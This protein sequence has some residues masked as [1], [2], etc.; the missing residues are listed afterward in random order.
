MS[1]HATRDAALERKALLSQTLT[2]AALAALAAEVAILVYVLDK[3]QPGLWFVL[4][5][6][7]ATVAEVFSILFG[8]WGMG[9]I[10]DAQN[11][12]FNLQAIAGVLGAAL[13][14]GS[15]FAQGKPKQDEMFAEL[16]KVRDS[17]RALSQN[18]H[19]LELRVD[20]LAR[21]PAFPSGPSSSL[22]GSKEPPRKT[23]STVPRQ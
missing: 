16:L 8:G 13:L 1:D 9:R 12:H 5:A 2:N 15:V 19:A 10:K 18:L 6:L 23:A 3:R 22:R 17:T 7:A 21:R 20:S 4:L 11:P 14:V